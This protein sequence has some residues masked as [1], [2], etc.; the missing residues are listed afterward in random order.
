VQFRRPTRP[1]LRLIAARHKAPPRLVENG[2]ATT[3]AG[4]WGALTADAFAAEWI[5]HLNRLA[6]EIDGQ[7][8]AANVALPHRQ[9]DA[10]PRFPMAV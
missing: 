7:L 4:T 5:S 1:V 2:I 10:A 3:A 9:G 8:L 6:S